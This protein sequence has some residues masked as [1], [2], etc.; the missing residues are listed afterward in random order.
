MLQ[1]GRD[2]DLTKETVGAETHGQL[3]MQ[4]LDGH[5]ALVAHVSREIHGRHATPPDLAV[6]VV[7]VRYGG[8]QTAEQVAHLTPSSPPP[9]PFSACRRSCARSPAAPPGTRG[10]SGGTCRGRA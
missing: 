3:G 2:L 10:I 9:I 5:R 1:P 4:H 6:E 8:L 7:A